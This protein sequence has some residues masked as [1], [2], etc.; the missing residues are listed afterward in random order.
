M[1]DKITNF[2]F[3]RRE[4]PWPLHQVMHTLIIAKFIIRCW[5]LYTCEN[6]Y[7]C[8]FYLRG[9]PFV[10]LGQVDFGYT[11]L[12]GR[13]CRRSEGICT[14]L[15]VLEQHD[16]DTVCLNGSPQQTLALHCQCYGNCPS[17]FLHQLLHLLCGRKEPCASHVHF[18]RILRRG[19]HNGSISW[20][21]GA[22]HSNVEWHFYQCH[23]LNIWSIY[24]SCS[25]N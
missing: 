5:T 14:C 12:E 6:L 13:V 17:C 7:S 24:T 20:L 1:N 10:L 22:H 15:G 18:T 9:H 4:Y 25:C 3:K 16:V 21:E 8:F 19:L 23:G 11:C 2:F